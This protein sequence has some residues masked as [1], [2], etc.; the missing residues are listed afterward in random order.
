MHS[1]EAEDGENDG[2]GVDGGEGVGRRD[3]EDVPDAVLLGVV[4]GPERD[5][6][7]EGEAEGV[8]D[9]VGRVQPHCWLQQHVHLEMS[10]LMLRALQLLWF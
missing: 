9:L 6:G 5:D 4:V 7:P 10:A 8:K 1:L 3:H 2:A